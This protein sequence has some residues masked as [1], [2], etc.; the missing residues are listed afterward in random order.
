MKNKMLA[1]LGEKLDFSIPWHL[2]I[3][4]VSITKATI[5]TRVRSV[6]F[7]VDSRQNNVDRTLQEKCWLFF[8]AVSNLETVVPY[9]KAAVQ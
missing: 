1:L 9:F 8:P 7:E 3:K 5:Y 6:R 2:K 4:Q